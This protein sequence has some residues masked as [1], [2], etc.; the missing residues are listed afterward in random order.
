MV[1]TI[2][3]F[4]MVLGMHVRPNERNAKVSLCLVA[5]TSLTAAKNGGIQ[6]RT[7]LN[8]HIITKTSCHI[9]KFVTITIKDAK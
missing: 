4:L 2:E 3:S 6:S 1:I 8:E 5:A 9:Y 7:M